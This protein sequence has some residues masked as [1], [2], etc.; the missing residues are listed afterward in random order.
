LGK[1]WIG[2]HLL[3]LPIALLLMLTQN[4]YVIDEFAILFLLLYP[5]LFGVFVCHTVL[6]E[7]SRKT[8]THWL[9]L[10]FNGFYLLSTKLFFNILVL[11]IHLIVLY[12]IVFFTFPNAIE[13]SMDWLMNYEITTVQLIDFIKRYLWY[14]F[15]DHFQFSIFIGLFF[16]LTLLLYKTEKKWL[17]VVPVLLFLGSNV[18]F[19]VIDPLLHLTGIQDVPGSGNVLIDLPLEEYGKFGDA[20]SWYYY[21]DV[22]V[23]DLVFPVF[24]NLFFIALSGIILDRWVRV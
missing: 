1:G 21:G 6:K 4:L 9:S 22:Y 7:W 10:P 12:F 23:S 20:L 8:I 19:I 17:A 13:K 14:I 2:F 16:L 3:L 15:Y 5:F 24:L 18:L 11:G